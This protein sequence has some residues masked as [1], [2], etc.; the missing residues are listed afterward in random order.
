MDYD[1]SDMTNPEEHELACMFMEECK[2]SGY[3]LD[4]LQ[5]D[6]TYKNGK[7]YVT[8]LKEE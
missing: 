5:K 1:C 7:I 2:A 3:G 6:G 8:K 4:I